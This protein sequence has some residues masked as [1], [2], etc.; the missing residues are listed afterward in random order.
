MVYTDPPLIGAP[1]EKVDQS[2]EYTR[3]QIRVDSKVRDVEH[4]H[5]KPT[6]QF[7]YTFTVPK[8]IRIMP[9]TYQEFMMY[10]DARRRA[11]QVKRTLEEGVG[12]SPELAEA[13]LTE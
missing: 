13:S 1:D 6:G 11:E 12:V 5:S 4:G 7:N 3:V 8:N 9:R 10:I 2:E